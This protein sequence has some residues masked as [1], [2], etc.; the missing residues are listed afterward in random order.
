M[1]NITFEDTITEDGVYVF[2]PRHPGLA[3]LLEISGTFGGGA[4]EVGYLDASGN[5]TSYG[6][7]KAAAGSSVVRIPATGRL[8]VAVSGSTTPVIRFRATPTRS[9]GD[10]IQPSKFLA[11]PPTIATRATS[12]IGVDTGLWSDGDTLTIGNVTY[13]KSDALDSVLNEFS[14]I[15]ELSTLINGGHPTVFSGGYGVSSISVSSYGY[16]DVQNAIA[17]NSSNT[18]AFLLAD[19]H[20]TGGTDGTP[21]HVGQI[22]FVGAPA[23]APGGGGGWICGHAAGYWLQLWSD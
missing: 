23:S 8:A 21:G 6:I 9:V 20:L 1:I 5:V 22:A 13:T 4:V 14:T 10:E 2:P 19:S 7:S 12:E 3:I 11:D 16:G 15:A 18:D 17:L